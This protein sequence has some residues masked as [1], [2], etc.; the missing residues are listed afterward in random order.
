ML[1]AIAMRA[2]GLPSRRDHDP[3]LGQ[4]RTDVGNI[5]SDETQRKC[6]FSGCDQCL[7]VPAVLTSPQLNT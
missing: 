6:N 3:I 2:H 4:R 7:Q 1:G 5:A